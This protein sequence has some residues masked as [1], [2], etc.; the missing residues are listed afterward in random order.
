L[1]D[2]KRT[3]D[4]IVADIQETASAAVERFRSSLGG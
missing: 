1:A 4:S 2:I 3:V